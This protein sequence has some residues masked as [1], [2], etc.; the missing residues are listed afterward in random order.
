MGK[1][2]G[3]RTARHMRVHRRKQR[4]HDLTYK[5]AHLGTALK[6]NPFGGASHAKGI[7]VEKLC[8]L[9]SNNETFCGRASVRL[10]RMEDGMKTRWLKAAVVAAASG[11]ND[12][13]R[14]NFVSPP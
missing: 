8:V 2:H 14:E 7:V 12:K 13:A 9:E 11:R 6:A 1:P 3:L 10:R 5:K 4:W